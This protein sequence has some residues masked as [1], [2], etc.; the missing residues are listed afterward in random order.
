MGKDL[1]LRREQV[2][3]RAPTNCHSDLHKSLCIFAKTPLGRGKAIFANI[4]ISLQAY[5]Q[6]FHLILVSSLHRSMVSRNQTRG[7]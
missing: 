7:R 6:I 4:P 2:H 5:L 3:Y 1:R